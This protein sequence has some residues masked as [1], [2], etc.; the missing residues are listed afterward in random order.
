MNHS[1][2]HSSLKYHN[3]NTNNRFS[4]LANKSRNRLADPVNPFLSD[5]KITMADVKNI[6]ALP[7]LQEI[8]HMWGMTSEIWKEPAFFCL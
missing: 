8:T 3:A 2:D 1:S 6:W 7:Q 5:P 4:F